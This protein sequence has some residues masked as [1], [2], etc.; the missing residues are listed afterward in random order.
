MSFLFLPAAPALLLRA[1]QVARRLGI[2]L[3][4]AW[5][6]PGGVAAPERAM[7]EWDIGNY[8]AW[9]RRTCV[10]GYASRCPG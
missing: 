10:N 5:V 7:P 4:D 6:L 1:R 3:D 2:T 9:R 8:I